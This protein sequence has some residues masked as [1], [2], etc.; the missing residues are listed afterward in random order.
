MGQFAWILIRMHRRP[1]L[2][3]PRGSPNIWIT[4]FTWLVQGIMVMGGLVWDQATGY[5]VHRMEKL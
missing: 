2:T 1:P 4:R 5:R 3:K